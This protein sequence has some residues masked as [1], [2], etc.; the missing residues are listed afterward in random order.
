MGLHLIEAQA[1]G[2]V[3]SRNLREEGTGVG[4]MPT[5]TVDGTWQFARRWSANFH[6]QQFS[7]SVSDVKGSLTD[8]HVDAQYRW[9]PNFAVG[10]GYAGIKTDV[11]ISGSGF[12]GQFA[13]DTRGPELFFRASF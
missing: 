6:A 3:R 5:G 10:L 7:V 12:P 8:Y 11:R 13:L 2:D 1:R 9:K 4:V